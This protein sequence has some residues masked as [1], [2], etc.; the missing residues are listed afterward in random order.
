MALFYHKYK[1]TSILVCSRLLYL[2][3]AIIICPRKQ[4]LLER[5]SLWTDRSPEP[6]SWKDMTSWHWNALTRRSAIKKH[7]RTFLDIRCQYS[8]LFSMLLKFVSPSAQS[9]NIPHVM[10][11]PSRSRYNMIGFHLPLIIS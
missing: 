2:V 10:D 8:A 4:G 7:W 6:R 5:G 3:F 11:S 9:K 1:H